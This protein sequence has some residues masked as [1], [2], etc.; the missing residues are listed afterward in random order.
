M[1]TDYKCMCMFLED[2]IKMPGIC[3]QIEPMNTCSHYSL[4]DAEDVIFKVLVNWRYA[5]AGYIL[6]VKDSYE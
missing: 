5:F 3:S 4:E 1:L 6:N 2:C